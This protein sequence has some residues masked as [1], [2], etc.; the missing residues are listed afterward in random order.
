[1]GEAGRGTFVRSVPDVGTLWHLGQAVDPDVID[2]SILVAP[3]VAHDEFG[4]ALESTAADVAR[5]PRLL[6]LLSYQPHAGVPAHREAAAQWLARTGLDAQPHRTVVCGSAQHALM[7]ALSVICRPGDAVFVEQLTNPGIKDF[8]AWYSL[9]LHG[10]PIDDEGLMPEP[11]E[12]AAQAKLAKALYCVPTLQNPTT[13]T[14]SDARRRVVADIAVRHG[15]AIVE[16]GVYG[17]LPSKPPVPLAAYAP[18]HAYYF[19]SLSKTVAP[20]LR[21]GYLHAPDRAITLLE[22]ALRATLWMASPLLAEIAARWIA[23]GTVHRIL[24][25]NRAEMV[26]RQK[27]AVAALRDFEVAAHP[28]GYHLWLRLPSTWR[29]AEF[30]LAARE[31]GRAHV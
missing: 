1:M 26:A 16:D 21:V 31:I 27:A 13:A 15:I 29:A 11:F 28:E 24:T 25:A 12:A 8:A 10:L 22:A 6:D 17:L 5:I 14:M 2:F 20:G 3:R 18:E 30:A 9:R 7:A 4:A 19:T 23:D